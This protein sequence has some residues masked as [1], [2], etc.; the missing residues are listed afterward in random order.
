M[1]GL[2]PLTGMGKVN[3]GMDT[4]PYLVLSVTGLSAVLARRSGERCPVRRGLSV[5]PFRRTVSSN[6]NGEKTMTGD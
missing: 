6:E 4:S 2:S 1:N 3:H 5:V